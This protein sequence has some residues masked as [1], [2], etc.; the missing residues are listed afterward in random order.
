MGSDEDIFPQKYF[1]HFKKKW[2]SQ[3]T[4][5]PKDAEAIYL[6]FAQKNKE[7]RRGG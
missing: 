7:R 3:G 6:E 2:Q 5:F 4:C 1:V